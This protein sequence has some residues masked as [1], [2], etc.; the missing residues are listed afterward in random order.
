MIKAKSILSLDVGHKRI[1]VAIGDDHLKIAI[2]YDTINV[3]GTE[4]EQIARIIVDEEVG[5]IVVGYPR[6]QSGE[7]T[8]QTAYVETFSNGLYD[9]VD[10][11]VFQDE[12]LSSVVAEQR[13]KAHNKPYTK[14]D[15]D[16]TAA[17]LF[18]QDYLN[19]Q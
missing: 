7:T 12:S 19:Q 4:Y 6:N 14:S 3:D 13:L 11:L 16:K 17:A 15:I 5:V 10:K 9:M 18:L 8:Q 1:G 2:P